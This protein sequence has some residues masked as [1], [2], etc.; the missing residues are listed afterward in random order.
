MK[1]ILKKNILS[2]I[3]GVVAI[4]AMVASFI[5]LGSY[6]ESLQAKLDES[7]GNYSSLENLL[8]K[9]R[10]KPIVS[11][12]ASGAE[13]L[14]TFP[15]EA[16]NNKGEQITKQ[17]EQESLRMRQVAEEMN[18]HDPLVPGALPLP[19]PGVDIVFR[20][21]YT[22]LYTPG[23]SGEL[24]PVVASSKGHPPLKAAT[25]PPE[26]LIAQKR[27]EAEAVIRSENES[28]GPGGQVTNVAEVTQLV[29]EMARKLPEQ[30][31]QD[32]A[33]SS[34]V[35]VDPG[36]FQMN[37]R[38]AQLPVGAR[39]DPIDIWWAQVQLWVQQDVLNAIAD[40]NAGKASVV[41]APV[42][43]LISVQVPVTFVAQ[44]PAQPGAPVAD[45]MNGN[46]DSPIPKVPTISMTGRVSNALY[47][48]IH[49][50]MIVD[51]EVAQMAQ[52]VRT[53]GDKRLITV[54]E[55]NVTSVDSAG[56][57]AKG[58]YYGTNPVAHLTLRCEALLMRKW[59]TPLM[60]PRVKQMLGVVEQPAAGA[61][62]PTAMAQ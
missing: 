6:K 7:K 9:P 31:R 4:G 24:P 19:S 25:P 35:Y 14:G 49:F 42:K 41:D 60:P 12:D 40:M 1:E 27:A 52:F 51:V 45:P 3:C 10:N 33:K 5:P 54:R 59:T 38:L 11:P 48:V 56:E 58:Y 16:V 36:T 26:V 47:D 53:L 22:K 34:M 61:A 55:M 39:P 8:T 15:N 20:E 50:D 44:T 23:L 43:H 21:T 28:R 2:I 30:M 37:Q 18:A 57:L 46:P 29:A 17:V 13:P 32:V 62:T